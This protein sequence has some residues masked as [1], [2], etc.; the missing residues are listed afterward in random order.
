MK[1]DIICNDGSP[2]GVHLSDIY[3]DGQKIGV[4]GAELAL[5]TMC[6]AWGASGHTVRLYNNPTHSE[7]APFTQLPVDTFIPSDERDVV[8][9][10]RSP[11]FRI[12]QV[13]CKK[14]WWST[15]QF[16]IGSFVKFAP[17]VDKIVTISPFHAEH[18]RKEY[19][20]HNTITI[21]LPVRVQ[22]YTEKV[23]KIKHRMVFC[24]VPDRGLGILNLAFPRIKKEIP[25]VS[26]SITSDY[27][28]WGVPEPR[29]DI[30]VRNFLGLDDVRFW[31][32]IPRRDMVREQQLAEVQAYPCSY[33]E[34]FCY[35]VAECQVAGAYPVT[36]NRGALVTT[37]MG[38]QM[39]GDFTDGYRVVDAFAGKV[40]ETMLN[41]HLKEM[42]E[43][44]MNK[45]TERFSLGRIM[46]EWDAVLND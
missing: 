26:L 32:A 36:S 39:D 3:G 22:D 4:G 30:W 5:L 21:D 29:N 43:A 27:R 23:D 34:L 14:I 35:S 8:I 37:N 28:L 6:E 2:L 20:I 11:N 10:F 41:P 18:F 16:T 9:V 17:K 33:D 1:I 40:I 42:Q 31:G 44:V 15:D 46:A 12:D 13:E 19:K 7:P 38:T 45:A 25:D 24:S